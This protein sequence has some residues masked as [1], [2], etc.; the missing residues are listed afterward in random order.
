M[1][2]P[3][4]DVRRAGYGK[5]GLEFLPRFWK[6]LIDDF[7]CDSICSAFQKSTRVRSLALYLFF[8]W[9]KTGWL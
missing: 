5:E 6:F 3:S 1:Y 8:E 4:F 9:S 7:L 2:V